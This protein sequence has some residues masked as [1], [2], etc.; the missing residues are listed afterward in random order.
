MASLIVL[1][2]GLGVA[3]SNCYESV[4]NADAY[5]AS[6][7]NTAWTGL[8]PAKEAALIRAT[9]ALDD[10]YAWRGRKS[11]Q[12]QGLAWPRTGAVDNDGFTLTLVPAKLKAAVCEAALVE[13]ATPGALVAALARGGAVKR[14]KVAGV[15]EEYFAVASNATRYPAIENLLK[16]LV[17]GSLGGSVK[18]RR[19]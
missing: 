12:E 7:G 9:F 2:T 15:E 3:G 17:E 6:H 16:S 13:L 10:K 11:S 8:D 4:A 18:V 5:H 1:E 19:G 14:A